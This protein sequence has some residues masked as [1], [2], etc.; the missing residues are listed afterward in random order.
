MTA[1]VETQEILSRSGMSV[2]PWVSFGDLQPEDANV[3]LLRQT[4]DP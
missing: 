2:L 4:H 1:V 3:S